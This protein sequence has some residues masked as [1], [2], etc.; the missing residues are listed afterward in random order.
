VSSARSKRHG[1]E[2]GGRRGGGNVAVASEAK[3]SPDLGLLKVALWF[4]LI[5]ATLQ[6]GLLL[7]ASRGVLDPVIEATANFTGACSTLTGV[8]ASV[9]GN[10]V[11]LPTRI[12]RIDLDCTGASLMLVYAA[13]VLAYPLSAKRKLVGLAIGLP[14]IVLANLLRLAAVTQLSGPLDDK[15]FL[16]VH[17]YLFEVAMVSV[18]II[19]W[20]SYLAWARRSASSR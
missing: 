20:G 12:L 19:A 9:A 14:I 3:L 2:G 4:F 18:V 15:A 7:L 1:T 10:E 5:Y 16:F 11:A 13:L 6:A 17:D 8:P